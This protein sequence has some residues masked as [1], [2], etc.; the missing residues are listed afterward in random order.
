MNLSP[1]DVY[2][3]AKA[4]TEGSVDDIINKNIDMSGLEILEALQ[5]GYLMYSV[6]LWA[7][8][9]GKELTSESL[10]KVTAFLQRA[11]S[12]LEIKG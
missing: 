12:N 11:L 5:E 6:E 3:Q 10:Y 4:A 1:V 7:S 8:V 9:K 2:L